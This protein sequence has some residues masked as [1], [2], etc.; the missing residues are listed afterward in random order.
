MIF[1]GGVHPTLFPEQTIL[2]PIVDV[3]VINEGIQ[4]V[5]EL[6]SWKSG[7]ISLKDIKGIAYRKEDG[8]AVI[9][10]PHDLDGIE[11]VPPLNFSLIEVEKYL[12]A[13]SVYSREMNTG[14]SEKIRLM[15]IIS[16]LGCCYKC[17]FCINVILK[18]KYRFKNAREIIDEAINSKETY[19]ANAFILYDED[20]IISKKR[21]EEFLSIIEEEKL[22]FY[23]RVW[24]R[25]SYFRENYLN[26]AMIERL[27]KCGIRSI[28]M[29]AESGPQR[30]LDIIDKGIKVDEILASARM[31]SGTK[32]TPRYSFIVGLDGET[33]EDTLMTYDLCVK[34]L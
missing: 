31:L 23:F 19:G 20:F 10:D 27:E 29:G 25:V 7:E 4:T 28:A 16:G 8:R 12:G 18:R 21:L 3:I 11:D 22:E 13:T 1:W 30:V 33:K 26:S 14:V 17:Q 34:L 24:G 5:K 32:I 15:P 9:T 2:E 6:V